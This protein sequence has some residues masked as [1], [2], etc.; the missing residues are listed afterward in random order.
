MSYFTQ[1]DIF[2]NDLAKYTFTKQC[3]E[4]TGLRL[5]EG[6]KKIFLNMAS[7]NGSQELVSLLQYM[8]D[9]RID[10]PDI[11]RRY[12]ASIDKTASI[13]MDRFL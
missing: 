7:K 10:N 8:K 6:T 13:F 12:H 3:E 11:G 4:V 5:K 2:K 1:E 9:T